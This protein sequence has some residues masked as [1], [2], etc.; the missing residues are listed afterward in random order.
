MVKKSFLV[1][2]ITNTLDGSEKGFI[3]CV[4]ELTNLQTHVLY[5]DQSNNDPFQV[6]LE[7]SDTIES[8]SDSDADSDCK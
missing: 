6:K 4:K 1:C 5:I 8:E 3:H 7:E 2:G